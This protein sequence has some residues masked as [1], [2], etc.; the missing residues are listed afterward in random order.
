MGRKKI[1]TKNREIYDKLTMLN[2][3]K[4][5]IIKN[6]KP[7]YIDRILKNI[8]KNKKILEQEIVGKNCIIKKLKPIN[9]D[10]Y[11]REF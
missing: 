5:V 10:I 6:T 3:S 11:L 2:F 9:F 4:S 7:V 1:L 8:N